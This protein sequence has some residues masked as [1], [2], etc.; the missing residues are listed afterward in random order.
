V[1]NG[2]NIEYYSTSSDGKPIYSTLQGN[3]NTSISIASGSVRAFTTSEGARYVASYNSKTGA[4]LGYQNT[5]NSKDIFKEIESISFVFSM[6]LGT[7]SGRSMGVGVL[8][9][10]AHYKDNSY[11]VIYS[12]D[13]RSGGH[14]FGP[15]PSGDPGETNAGKWLVS[16]HIWNRFQ[17]G[18]Y[19]SEGANKVGFSMKLTP[20]FGLG[21]NDEVCHPLRGDFRIHPDGNSPGSAGCIALVESVNELKVFQRSMQHYFSV[22]RTA[23]LTVFPNNVPNLECQNP[24][25]R[26]ANTSRGRE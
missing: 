16:K 14:G 21:C 1:P 25:Y 20:L 5:Q 17:K 26:V 11:E 9:T 23:S 18:Y 15:L 4:F 3:P 13:A 10:I 24:K 22:N 7:V 6:S 12:Y 8:N 2:S 19:I